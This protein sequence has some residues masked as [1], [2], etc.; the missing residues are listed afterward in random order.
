MMWLSN[1]KIGNQLEGG[2]EVNVSMFF[3]AR[4]RRKEIGVHIVYE[5]E[6]K[7]SQYDTYVSSQNIIDDGFLS[8]YKMATGSYLFCHHCYKDFQERFVDNGWT[9]GSH[10][11]LGDLLMGNPFHNV[12]EQYGD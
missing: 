4:F 9:D 6:E 5:Q 3:R 1:W 12:N 10:S 7:G 11:A 8:A 2:D